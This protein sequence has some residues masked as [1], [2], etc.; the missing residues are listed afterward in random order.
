MSLVHRHAQ[1]ACCVYYILK[2]KILIGLIVEKEGGPL[3]TLTIAKLIKNKV[4][5][6]QFLNLMFNL[7][8]NVPFKLDFAS[9][10]YK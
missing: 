6:H 4:L 2:V 7:H 1:E 3:E 9:E 8:Y 10:I 5:L